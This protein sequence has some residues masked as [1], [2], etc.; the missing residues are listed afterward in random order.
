MNAWL[1]VFNLC[2]LAFTAVAFVTDIRWWRLPNWL[3]VSAFA[4]GLLFHA[5]LGYFDDGFAGTLDHL[6]FSLL[7]FGT[8][9]GLLFV[10]WLVGSASAGDAKLMGALGAWIGPIPVL[11]VLVLSG[12]FE[13]LRLVVLFL[14]RSAKKG[15]RRTIEEMK[16][17]NSA[18]DK[19]KET[20]LKNL[21]VPYAVN[22]I[23]ATWC[24]VIGFSLLAVT[25]STR[26][27]Q[28]DSML[29][30]SQAPVEKAS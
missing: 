19:P 6:R 5:A 25:N 4:A 11:C 29:A 18:K 27:W 15:M 13:M 21:T 7:G 17:N 20:S 28:S 10:A 2:V 14:M 26:Y 22:I 30:E 16:R 3:T 24:V 1:V 12:V 8:G 9:L 23:V